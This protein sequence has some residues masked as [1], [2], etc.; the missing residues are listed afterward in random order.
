[1]LTK[2]RIDLFFEKIAG[3]TH[4]V[5]PGRFR[6]R[7][8][9][10]HNADISACQ[11]SIQEALLV[12]SMMALSARFSNAP[13]FS[14]IPAHQRGSLFATHA[15]RL[16]QEATRL[17]ELDAP[18][19]LLLLQGCILLAIYQITCRPSTKSWVT[20]G[21]GCRLAL[22]LGLNRIDADILSES[23]E[24]SLTPDEWSKREEQRRAWWLI[25]ELDVF[26]STVL[27]RP[28]S[29]DRAQMWVLLPV[30]D[31]NWEQ[32]LQV[33]SKPII[34][35]ASRAWESLRDSEN[36]D[37]RAWFLVCTFLMATAHDM[38]QR[39]TTR[40]D[41]RREFG[42]TLDCFSLLLPQAF[43]LRRLRFDEDNCSSSNWVIALYFMLQT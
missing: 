1:M 35:D 17:E 16:Y 4:L 31:S 6:A 10:Q 24:V 20:I 38:S 29:L 8:H 13:E 9:S 40:E 23:D 28:Y 43:E 26:S 7:F 39:P 27:R 3:F 14:A 5:H 41:E 25:W 32:N 11:L 42:A 37:G 18:C 36:Q 2:W 19:S 30:S 34:A 21:T 12:Y 15:S 33:E 22:E